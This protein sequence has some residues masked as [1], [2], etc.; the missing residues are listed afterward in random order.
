MRSRF[1]PA[2]SDLRVGLSAPLPW[3]STGSDRIAGFFYGSRLRKP[4]DARLTP[5]YGKPAEDQTIRPPYAGAVMQATEVGIFPFTLLLPLLA[6][7]RGLLLGMR[8]P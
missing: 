8:R 3:H 6:L 2:R 7:G 5:P 4:S 1:A